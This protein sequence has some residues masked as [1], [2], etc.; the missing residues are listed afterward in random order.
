MQKYTA[1]SVYFATG[2]GVTHFLL[3]MYASDRGQVQTEFARLFGT[4]YTTD[5]EITEGFDTTSAPAK[6]LLSP[7]AHAM[8]VSPAGDFRL[9]AMLHVN[10]A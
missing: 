10:Y 9:S 4:Y 8:M 3:Y 2:E 1:T 6:L 5:I 7:K